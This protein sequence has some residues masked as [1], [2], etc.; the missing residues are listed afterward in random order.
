M[1]RHILL[2]EPLSA[3][4][5]LAALAL[6]PAPLSS[7][8]EPPAQKAE[9]V[10]AD[11]ALP[12]GASSINE[13]YGDWVVACK[14]VEDKKTCTFSQLHTN[15]QT[16]QPVFAIEFQPPANGRTNSVILLPF[17]LRLDDGVT[18]TIDGRPLEPGARFLTCFPSGC[19][20]PIA[21][22][23]AATDAMKD[24]EKL[25]VG[26]N[27]SSEGEPMTFTISLNGFT[28]ALSRIMALSK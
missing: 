10:V 9:I 8:D 13:A 21:F 18:L 4:V 28:A 11:S 16:G 15:N 22:P 2:A 5:M 26:A 1:S 3:V 12:N 7:V 25:I 6:S 14:R 20:V 23:T 17:G 19:L 24:G 27:S